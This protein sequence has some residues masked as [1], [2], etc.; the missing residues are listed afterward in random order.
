MQDGKFQEGP[1]THTLGKCVFIFAGGT[2]WRFEAFGAFEDDDRLKH[3]ALAKGPDFTSR[4]DGYYNVLGPNQRYLPPFVAD[5][6]NKTEI[7]HRAWATPNEK[8]EPDLT[9]IFYPIR[10]A[11]IIRAQFKCGP[12][13]RIDFDP[14]LLTALLQTEKYVHGARSLEKVLEPLRSQRNLLAQPRPPVRANLPAPNQMKL[15]VADPM[16]FHRL[17]RDHQPDP[18]RDKKKLD[19]LAR[20]IHGFWA[21]GIRSSDQ[22]NP[23]NVGWDDLSDD[24]KSSNFAAAYRI[25]DILAMAGLT[26]KGGAETPEHREIINEHIELHLDLLA[27]AEHDGWMQNRKANRWTY[28]PVRDDGQ[29]KHPC[30]KPF[31][32]L[33]KVEQDKD[34]NTV[35]NYP[36]FVS[37]VGL[38]IQ[39]IDPLSKQNEPLQPATPRVTT[40]K[41]T[42]KRNRRK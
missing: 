28:D 1:L 10:R 34:R 30:L 8:W 5:S 14:G 39:F 19:V 12:S 36:N 33:S 41:R 23:N 13:D 27:E 21:K 6:D 3:F 32:E 31:A 15:H 11:L 24:A 25:P 40:P 9:D 2:A 7:G 35:R 16:Q 22:F 26:L 29:R 20:A 18:F 17:C 42:P 37:L 38:T 4:L